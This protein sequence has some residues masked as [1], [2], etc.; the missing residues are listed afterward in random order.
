MIKGWYWCPE[1]QGY[2]RWEEQIEYYAMKEEKKTGWQPCGCT[3]HQRASGNGCLQCNPERAY[4]IAKRLT[5]E[6]Q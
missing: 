4:E 3:H 1:R 2:Q 5:T 6:K